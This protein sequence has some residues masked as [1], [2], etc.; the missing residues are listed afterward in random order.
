[1]MGENFI[2]YFSRVSQAKNTYYVETDDET[3]IIRLIKATGIEE[4]YPVRMN[5]LF[6]E[7]LTKFDYILAFGKC[8]KI[9]SDFVRKAD[10]V[11]VLGGD[12]FTEAY[13][14]RGPVINGIKFNALRRAGRKVVMLGQTIGPFLSFRKRLMHSLLRKIDKIYPR[15]PVTYKYLSDLGLKNITLMDDLALLPLAKQESKERT[16]EYVTYFPSELI[17]RYSQSGSR[18][19]WIDF[20]TFAIDK[21]MQKYPEKK[22]VLL[23]HVLRPEHADDRKITEEL[24]ARA[25]EKYEGRIIPANQ[26]MLPYEVRNYIQKSYLVVSGRMHPAVSAMQSEIPVIAF[27][28]SEKYWGIIGERYG[29]GEYILDIR[30]C[31]YEKMKD[32]FCVLL[33]KIDRQYDEIQ[34]IMKTGNDRAVRSIMNA[35]SE[36]NGLA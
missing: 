9:T 16:K 5:S 31:S 20:N 23:A 3:N 21:I 2:S 32:R 13:G 33:D 18:E 4:I 26:E 10:L 27:A 12:D 14:W 30:N 19:D 22:L 25:N 24:Y 7:N 1:M 6:K 8:K 11:V 28:Y 29:L 17:Y 36:I 35:L 34:Q 15:D